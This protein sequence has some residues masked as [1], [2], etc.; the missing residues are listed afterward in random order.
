MKKK[1]LSLLLAAAMVVGLVAGCGAKETGEA[2]AEEATNVTEEGK[3]EEAEKPKE[4]QTVR[5]LCNNDVGGDVFVED[6]EEYEISK[7][8]VQDLEEIGVRLELECVAGDS[9][10]NVVT[11]RMAAGV[12]LPDLVSWIWTAG[13]RA[14]VLEWAESGLVYPINE[15][16]EQ[17][18]EDGSVRKFYDEEAPGAWELGT[19]L[20]GN[21]YWISCILSENFNKR[22]DKETGTEYMVADPHTLSIRADW[23]EA[24][25]EEVKEVYTPDEL[26]AIVKKMQDQD[27][28]GNGEKDEIIYA[29]I[30]KFSDCIATGFGLTRNSL[31]GY[32]ENDHKVFSNFYHENF[33]AYIEFMQKLY[34]EGLYDTEALSASQTEMVAQDRVAVAGNYAGWIYEQSLPEFDENKEYYRPIIID[35]DGDLSNGWAQ[36]VDSNLT[37]TYGQFFVPKNCENPEAVAKLID[38]MYTERYAAMCQFGREGIN[39]NL[40]ENGNYVVIPGV[41]MNKEN[42]HLRTGGFSMKA[43][44]YVLTCV[45]VSEL[46]NDNPPSKFQKTEFFNDFVINKY[47]T[48]EQVEFTAQLTGIPTE[49]EQ[50]FMDEKFETLKT[51]ARELTADLILGNKSLDDMDEHLAE[52]EKLGLKEYIDIVQAQH[53]RVTK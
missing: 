51:F 2:P 7:V 11:T 24:V 32:F 52:L 19:A 21:N 35:L 44:P 49:E 38:Y 42:G 41:E 37:A 5:I 20:D 15:L 46:T 18:D 13:D 40:D 47:P 36:A 26:A 14:S 50:A 39:Y 3:E 34:K 29:E 27:A 17:Y 43:L 4:L 31:A 30:A 1:V 22:V 12:D 10:E 6:W 23:V 45:Q 16:L 33:P 8:L 25:G 53:D 9:F 28:N 48:L